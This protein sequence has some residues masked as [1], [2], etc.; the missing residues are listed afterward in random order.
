MKLLHHP[1]RSGGSE[2]VREIFRES[3]GGSEGDDRRLG[4]P[5]GAHVQSHGSNSIVR[6]PLFSTHLQNAST[7][8]TLVRD[9]NS[10]TSPHLP[11]P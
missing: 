9:Y 4:C 1:T 11:S 7:P 10:V 6:H 8:S 2:T 5:T 3:D